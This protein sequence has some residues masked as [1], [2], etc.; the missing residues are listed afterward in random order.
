MRILGREGV[1]IGGIRGAQPRGHVVQRQRNAGRLERANARARRFTHPAFS[2]QVPGEIDAN[3]F[4]PHLVADS[5]VRTARAQRRAQA[6]DRQLVRK[7][8]HASAP[9]QLQ[10]LPVTASPD[11]LDLLARRADVSLEFPVSPIERPKL[12]HGCVKAGV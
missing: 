8:F 5:A 2:V 11:L 10:R 12:V 6:L 3:G 9:I 1:A 7:K 4:D